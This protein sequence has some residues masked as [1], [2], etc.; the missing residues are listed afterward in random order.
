MNILLIGH[1]GY[2]GRGLF[3]YLSRDHRVLGWDKKE[4][5]FALDAA[6]LAR[7]NIEV[8][9][10]LSVMADRAGATIQIDTPG[11]KVNIGGARHLARILK[12]SEITWFQ[13]STR[14]VLGPIYTPRDVRKTKAGYRPKIL[15]DESYPYAPRNAYAKSKIMAEFISESHPFSNIIRL[16]TGYTDNYQAVAGW[17][18]TLITAAVEGKLVTLTRGGEQFRDPL[19]TDDLARLIELICRKKIFG[20]KFHAGGGKKNYI[21]L[22]EFVRLANPKVKILKAKGGDY[23]FA[24]DISKA[25]KLTGWEPRILLRDKMPV[26]VENVRRAKGL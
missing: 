14:E 4:D 10:N 9:I 13:F 15:I 17:M 24:F 8:A 11:D 5:L 2:V 21:S 20:E 7:K 23:G 22:K 12:G 25:R 19:H 18:L 26:I 6:L 1:E 3:E 16:T